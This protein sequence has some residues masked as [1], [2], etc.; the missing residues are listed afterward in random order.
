M[1]QQFLT[2]RDNLIQVGGSPISL[3]QTTKTASLPVTLA[4]DQGNLGTTATP[5]QATPTTT[6]PTVTDSTS[7]TLVAA[8]ASRKYLLIQNDSAA[9]VL[10]SLSGATLT[11]IVPTSTNKGIVL[12]PGSSYENPAHYCSTAAIT[13]YQ[14]S[15][16]PINTIT[17]VEG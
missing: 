5:T 13:V 6:T 16:G 12:V 14:T 11:G 1:S 3:G 7:F 2:E 10:V 4:S 8:N 9:N 17:A 15:G